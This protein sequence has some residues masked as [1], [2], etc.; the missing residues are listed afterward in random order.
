[1]LKNFPKFQNSGIYGQAGGR[2]LK[3]FGIVKVPLVQ[4][5]PLQI[6]VQIADAEYDEGAGSDAL[7][8]R[9]NGPCEVPGLG[10]EM[11]D[12]A[13]AA[14]EPELDTDVVCPID[15]ES[16]TALYKQWQAGGA[17]DESILKEFGKAT[18]D[19]LQA[20]EAVEA[21]VPGLEEPMVADTLLDAML[22]CTVPGVPEA[23]GECAG[24][25]V[26]DTA[27]GNPV[28]EMMAYRCTRTKH[29]VGEDQGGVERACPVQLS[30]SVLRRKKAFKKNFE[31]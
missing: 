30:D 12:G 6:L 1:M 18:L 15:F 14:P 5:A 17:T 8:V 7:T 31:L 13:M 10:H 4:G 2:F 26:H 9:V 28:L 19:M 21:G 23:S 3:N 25:E 16:C 20:Q 29:A 22:T 24:T 27:G 11:A